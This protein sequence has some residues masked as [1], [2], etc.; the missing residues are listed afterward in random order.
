[1]TCIFE[2]SFVVLSPMKSYVNYPFRVFFCSVTMM[3]LL[4]LTIGSS[5]AYN[6]LSTHFDHQAASKE[7]SQQHDDTSVPFENTTEEKAEISANDFASEYLRVDVEQLVK[8]DIPVNHNKY[9]P[10][11]E[12]ANFCCDSVSPPPETSVC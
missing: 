10:A 5:F 9:H 4:W 8:T 1:M 11:G 6:Q 7:Q 12:F 2:P 3:T